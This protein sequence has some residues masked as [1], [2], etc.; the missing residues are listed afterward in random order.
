[1][2]IIFNCIGIKPLFYKKGGAIQKLVGY[3][4]L[5]L[6]NEHEIIIAGQMAEAKEGVRLIL[7]KKR[8]PA[9]SIPDF[10]INGILGLLKIWRVEA[11]MIISTHQRNFL[12]SFLY[13]KL[14]KKPMIAWEMDH[15]F[16]TPPFSFAKR[17][18]HRLI[19]KVN[20]IV[21][22]SSA[23]KKRMIARGIDPDKI[24][25]VYN[26]IDTD[27][28]S[29]AEKG[30]EHPKYLLYV[31]KFEERKNQ[32][33][34]LE[35]FR[36]LA[37]RYSDIKL[38]LV[39]PGSGA[40]TSRNAKPGLYFRKCAKYIQKH[41]LEQKVKIF[42]EITDEELIGLYRN[43]SIFV[44]PSLEEGFGMTLLE[45][46]SCGCCCISNSIETSAE[47]IGNAGILADVKD[48]DQFVNKIRLLLDDDSIREKYKAAARERAVSTFDSK[49]S[50]QQFKAV[51][52]SKI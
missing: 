12:S 28:F 48:L 30:K 47:I 14:K 37:D 13:S 27:K 46:M 42:E 1:M 35:V 25:I 45:A 16:W 7:N 23:Q 31:A 21:T 4:I 20:Q 15:V 22:E 24:S 18:Y 19:N 51:L 5:N 29:P 52:S 11:D 33:F 6:K 34:L 39:G 8:A 49:I 44:F 40:F 9:A 43:A 2:K 36:K 32:L 26:S 10:F 50:S 3:Q 38:Y 41:S 17:I